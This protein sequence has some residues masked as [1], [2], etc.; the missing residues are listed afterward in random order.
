MVTGEPGGSALTE[1][2]AFRFSPEERAQLA[3]M[4][5]DCGAYQRG[6]F[7]LASGKKSDTYIDVKRGLTRPDVLALIAS[8]MAPFIDSDRIAGV[9][10]AGVPIA[11]AVSLAVDKPC[12]FVRKQPKEH[13]TKKRIEGE[14]KSGDSVTFVEDV[15]TTGGSV[16]AGI[17]AVEEA[18]GRVLMVV[19]VVD[20]GEGAEEALLKRGV[21]LAIVLDLPTLRRTHDELLAL[22]AKKARK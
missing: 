7:T 4:L 6:D 18:G 16:I 14:L 13:G 22:R 10:L 21:E 12:I 1:Q 19:T 17:E 9:E 5:I 3:R 2:S 8:A 20:R 15:T 11:A